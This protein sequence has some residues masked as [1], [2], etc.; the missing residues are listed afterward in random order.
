[1]KA[2]FF[3]FLAIL[4]LSICLGDTAYAK[5][6]KI[7][8]I[9]GEEK[10][11]FRK[12]AALG[13]QLNYYQLDFIQWR[14]NKIRGTKNIFRLLKPAPSG[15]YYGLLDFFQITVNKISSEKIMP[16]E[17]DF[18][19]YHNDKRFGCLMKLNF[20]G[21]KIILDWYMK[22]NSQL[23]FCE[24]STAK[25][26]LKPV[27][28][29]EFKVT[30]CP[31][32]LAKVNGKTVYGGGDVYRREAL[33][34]VKTF[35]KMRSRAYPLTPEDKYL[36]LQDDRYQPGKLGGMGPCL[37]TLNYSG[38]TK[39]LLYLKN[40]WLTEIKVKAKIP[41]KKVTFALWESKNSYT[42]KAFREKMEK[43]KNT[44]TLE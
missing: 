4:N 16:N 6:I 10:V 28:S 30:A 13:N 26:S 43:E 34:P 37:F 17:Q 32:C 12:H 27:K 19:A 7:N 38:V 42:N 25:N 31:S 20:D 11:L 14:P 44:F 24:I 23:L 8:R 5:W 22:Q 33:S 2:A 15:N 1:M 9:Y 40:S 29:L 36:I 35:K 41:L 21:A 39:A 18:T 3:I